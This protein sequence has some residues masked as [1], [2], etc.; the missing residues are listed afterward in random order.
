MARTPWVLA[1]AALLAPAGPPWMKFDDARMAAASSDKLVAVYATVGANGMRD[2]DNSDAANEA[3]ASKAVV[4]RYGEFFWVNAGDVPTAKRVDAPSNGANLIFVD[5][6]GVSVGAWPV[7]SGGEKAMLAALDEAKG[8]YKSKPVPWSRGEPE[9]VSEPFKRKLIVY[10]FL[11][12]K[13]ASQKV[14][15]ALEHP[16]VAK[17]FGRMAFLQVDDLNS[18]IARRFKVTS[19]PTLIFYDPSMKEGKE[20]IERRSGETNTRQVRVPIRKF[21]DKVKKD[22]TE[23]K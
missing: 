21:L 6:D 2:V 5:P 19:F 15:K 12:G 11:D 1:A 3:L 8:K 18:P 7:Q 22:L 23:G 4:A 16:W 9:P 10:A 17:D 13:E 14:E 20:V